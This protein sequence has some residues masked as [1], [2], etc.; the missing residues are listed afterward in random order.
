MLLSN[1]WNEEN[2]IMDAEVFMSLVDE[3]FIDICHTPYNEHKDFIDL[4]N[5]ANDTVLEYAENIPAIISDTACIDIYKTAEERVGD[6]EGQYEAFINNQSDIKADGYLRV[7]ENAV[8]AM[9]NLRQALEKLC[10]ALGVSDIIRYYDMIDEFFG[11]NPILRQCFPSISSSALIKYF[12]SVENLSDTEYRIKHPAD[13]FIAQMMTATN[14]IEKEYPSFQ[15]EMRALAV[16]EINKKAIEEGTD[17]DPE[18]LDSMVEE[19]LKERE[20]EPKAIYRVTILS[21]R[22]V[23]LEQ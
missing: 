7:I 9:N 17:I 8:F 6:I 11:K 21:T 15:R 18:E 3:I 4:L 5:K 14:W 20:N 22:K 19:W 1:N 16:D 10:K 2:C 23:K 12:A 13:T